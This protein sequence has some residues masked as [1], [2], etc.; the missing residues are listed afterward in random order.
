MCAVL[1]DV[2]LRPAELECAAPLDWRTLMTTISERT[3]HLRWL[4]DSATFVPGTGKEQLPIADCAPSQRRGGI[5]AGQI[6]LLACLLDYHLVQCSPILQ[7][8]CSTNRLCSPPSGSCAL[9]LH[10]APSQGPPS[11]Q[12]ARLSSPGA[13]PLLFAEQL[14]FVLPR[15]APLVTYHNCQPGVLWSEPHTHDQVSAF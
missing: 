5:R 3:A 15:F 8:L 1:K 13:P 14:L 11:L 7:S 10:I 4:L 9:Y 6:S 12:A 2:S